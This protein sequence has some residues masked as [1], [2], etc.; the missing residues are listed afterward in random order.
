MREESGSSAEGSMEAP[1]ETESE[2]G[3]E[4]FLFIHVVPVLLIAW[5]VPSF[6]VNSWLLFA[7]LAGYL[8]WVSASF[9]WNLM[10]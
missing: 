10:H 8:I 3:K 4:Q 9:T 5:V 6:G 2:M 7:L 1:G